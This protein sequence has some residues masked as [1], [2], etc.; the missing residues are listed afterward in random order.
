MGATFTRITAD[1]LGKYTQMFELFSVRQG[2]VVTCA[3]NKR[4]ME[5]EEKKEQPEREL[6]PPKETEFY[7]ILG[8]DVTA[9]T[10]QIKKAYF[11]KARKC[12][13]DKNPDNPEAEEE[14]KKLS[15]A[16]QVLSDP[17]TREMYHKLG[18]AGIQNGPAMDPRALFG[19]LFGGGKF[20]EL[21]GEISLF[22]GFFIKII[23]K[24]Q[25]NLFKFILVLSG[26]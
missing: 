17:D 9:T 2:R 15:T 21:I 4:Q 6:P 18:E 8:V 14:F 22:C 13:P 16:Y 26:G 12:H 25:K 10:G 7:E 3:I 24:Q 11:L 5:G 1:I 19:M 20:D 23:F